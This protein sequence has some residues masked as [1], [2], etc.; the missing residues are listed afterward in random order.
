MA[1]NREAAPP[2]YKQTSVGADAR[3]GP[4]TLRRYERPGFPGFEI[5][6]VRRA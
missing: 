2:C 4:G 3:I 6:A 5:A 1:A